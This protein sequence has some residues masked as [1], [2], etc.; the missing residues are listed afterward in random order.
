MAVKCGC[1]F[2]V[3]MG[4]SE[5]LRAENLSLL[6]MLK[7]QRHIINTTMSLKS[8]TEGVYAI[9]EL[10][11]DTVQSQ[12]MYLSP[13]AAKV[14]WLKGLFVSSETVMHQEGTDEDHLKFISEVTPQRYPLIE[15]KSTSWII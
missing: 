14:W 6:D 2:Q 7:I 15:R 5:T 11:K 9:Y 3:I 1:S 10:R 4:R 13:T 8:D 12:P